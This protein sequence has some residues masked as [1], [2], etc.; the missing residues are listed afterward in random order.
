MFDVMIIFTPSVYSYTRLFDYGIALGI[1]QK[2]ALFEIKACHDAYILLMQGYGNFS[3]NIIEIL[4][5]S[6]S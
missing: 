2:I 3:S 1:G 4:I 6:I 5:G